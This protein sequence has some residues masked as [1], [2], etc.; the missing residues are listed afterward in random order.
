MAIPLIQIDDL[1][2]KLA[3]VALVKLIKES[4]MYENTVEEFIDEIR[5]RLDLT[6]IDHT[7]YTG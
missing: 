1:K 4:N 3:Y 7:H 5:M 6:D 2:Q